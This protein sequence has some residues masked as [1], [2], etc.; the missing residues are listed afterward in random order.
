MTDIPDF[1]D[2]AKE[3]KP[4]TSTADTLELAKACIAVC[5]ETKAE[6]IL[7]FDVQGKSALGDY[8]I[9]CCGNSRPHLRALA[10]HIKDAMFER[11]IRPRRQ[12]G[13]AGEAKWIVLDF[14]AL[15]IHILDKDSREFYRL[16]ELWDERR[17]IYRGP[18][19]EKSNG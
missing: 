16:E 5:E 13:E 10:E 2:A 8:F 19:A 15:I 9:V 12:D 7:L 14:G 4:L 18:A 17:I 6:N 3:I 11:G 1:N